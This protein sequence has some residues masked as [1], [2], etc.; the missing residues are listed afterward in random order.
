MRIP[1]F[2]R[3]VALGSTAVAIATG[4]IVTIGYFFEGLP[5]LFSLRLIFVQWAVLLASVALLVGMINLVLVH[6]RKIQAGGL[7]MVY[8]LVLIISLLITFG[9]G[10]FFGPD[11]PWPRWVF[12]NIQVPVEATLMAVLA[13]ALAYA[14]ARV[15]HRR[16]N[17]LSLVFVFT[18]LIVLLGSGSFLW[19]EIPLVSD[20]F[21]P[22]LSRVPAAAGAR[23]ILVGVALG[24]IATGL[25]VLMGVD[26]P[27]GG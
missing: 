24:T 6:I 13:V 2:S 10:T 18:A 26:R 15:L 4:V 11:H 1:L 3:I 12:D 27:Y 7:N 23:G 5:E 8:S 14:S 22:W 20:V 17:I 16:I 25:R 19:G 21:A 9:L